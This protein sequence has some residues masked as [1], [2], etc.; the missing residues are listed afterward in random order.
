[1]Q[2][3][4]KQRRPPCKRV[5]NRETGNF[6]RRFSKGK[7]ML[8]TGQLRYID[9]KQLPGCG[10]ATIT[11]GATPYT[12]TAVWKPSNVGKRR[13]WM[14]CA[15]G[16]AVKRLYLYEKWLRC[17]HCLRLGYQSQLVDG[18]TRQIWREDKLRKMLPCGARRP[19]GMHRTTYRRIKA[20][21]QVANYMQDYYFCQLAARFLR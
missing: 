9:A 8:T 18:H 19:K 1:M 15:C 7:S 17:R 2:T 10:T 16:R 21:I 6:H 11:S 12:F 4:K 14:R 20:A 5:Y 13:L 3:A